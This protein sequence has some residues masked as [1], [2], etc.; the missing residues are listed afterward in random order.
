MSKDLSESKNPIVRNGL[1]YMMLNY[2]CPKCGSE[3][4]YLLGEFQLIKTEV[5]QKAISEGISHVPRPKGGILGVRCKK[6]SFTTL[7]EAN[8]YGNINAY[9]M[10]GGNIGFKPQG[11]TSIQKEV[12][13]YFD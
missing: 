3:D 12:E 11:Y 1:H 8:F 5:N 9:D 10:G 7:F 13:G 6:C 2:K 4:N